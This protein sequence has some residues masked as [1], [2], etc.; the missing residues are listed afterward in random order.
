MHNEN[1]GHYLHSYCRFYPLYKYAKC[2]GLFLYRG[3]F[4][5]Q[6][7]KTQSYPEIL[8]ISSVYQL[9]IWNRKIGLD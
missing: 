2:A 3:I 4:C 8:K 7:G 6:V 5:A 1:Q 9:N